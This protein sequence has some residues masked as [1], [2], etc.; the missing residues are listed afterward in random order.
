MIVLAAV[1]VEALVIFAVVLG[2]TLGITYWASSRAS[3]AA[4][5]YAAGRQITGFQR[6]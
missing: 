5:F 1:N 2:I 3:G 4:G 6:L